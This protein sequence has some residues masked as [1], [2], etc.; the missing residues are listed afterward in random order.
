MNIADLQHSD[1]V[2][3]LGQDL[4][5]LLTNRIELPLDNCCPDSNPN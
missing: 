5:G 2:R 3:A 1:G 4:D